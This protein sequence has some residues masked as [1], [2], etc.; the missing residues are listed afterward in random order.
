MIVVT[1]TFGRFEGATFFCD[2]FV[3]DC[4]CGDCL[5]EDCLF[6][7]RFVGDSVSFPSLS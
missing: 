7:E 5:D 4:L 6:G 2:L 3:G 1:F